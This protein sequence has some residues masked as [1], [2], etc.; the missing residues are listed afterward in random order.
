MD[1]NKKIE[2]IIN[3]KKWIKNDTGLWKIQCCKLFKDN[4]ELMLFIVTDELNGPAVARV[5]KVVVTNNSSELVMFYDNEY[6]A[7]LEEDEYEHYSEFLT[8]EEW[9]VLFSGNAA[10]ELFE[11]DM[12]SEEEGFYVEPHE[13]IE[14]FMNNYDKEISEEIAGYFNL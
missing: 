4:G 11:M 14:R 6:D 12:L 8:R 9:D 3:N 2:D 5:E 1:W 10:K 7:V 13:G